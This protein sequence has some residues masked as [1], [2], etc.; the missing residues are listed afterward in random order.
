MQNN[1]E[2]WGI[3]IYK[4]GNREGLQQEHGKN[5]LIWH[6]KNR[7]KVPEF[8]ANSFAVVTWYATR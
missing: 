3:K 6:S 7:K 5:A 8:E 4:D 2:Q 1:I